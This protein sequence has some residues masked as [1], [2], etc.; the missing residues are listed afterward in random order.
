MG[1]IAFDSFEF[2][3]TLRDAGFEEKQAEA[4]TRAQVKSMEQ[5]YKD[6]DYVSRSELKT[7]INDLRKDMQQLEIG[8]RNEVQAVSMA[9]RDSAIRNEAEFK[10]IRLMMGILSAGVGAILLKLFF[11]H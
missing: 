4:L 2:N 11:P 1:S 6:A 10:N 5:L 7:D 8:M 3:K 9:V